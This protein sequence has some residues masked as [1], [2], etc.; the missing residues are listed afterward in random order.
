MIRRFFDMIKNFW[1]NSHDTSTKDFLVYICIDFSFLINGLL[2]ICMGILPVLVRE[3]TENM[4]RMMFGSTF[5]AIWFIFLP[6]LSMKTKDKIVSHFVC[7]FLSLIMI[8]VI[9]VYWLYFGTYSAFLVGDI[10]ITIISIPICAYFI[11]LLINF[12]RLIFFVIKTIVSRILPSTKG[13]DRG[14]VFTLETITS[15]LV[16]ISSLVAAFWGMITG[17][18]SFL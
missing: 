7:S 16:A 11:Y 9:I 17:I 13:K 14:L 5:I 12:F 1:E 10:V 8:V 18:K 6:N 3:T 4:F 2:L 15:I